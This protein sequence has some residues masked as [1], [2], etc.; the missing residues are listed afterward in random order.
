MELLTT[1]Q[2][3]I[4]GE[5]REKALVLLNEAKMQVKSTDRADVLNRMMELVLHEDPVSLLPEFVPYL[6]EFQ[7]DPDSPVRENVAK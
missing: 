1:Q 3:E 7:A 5:I 4:M 6:L 2:L